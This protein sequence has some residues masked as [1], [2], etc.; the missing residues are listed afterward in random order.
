MSFL[1]VSR[2]VI[3]LLE[4][5]DNVGIATL[6]D[7]DSLDDCKHPK[8]LM[9]DVQSVIVFVSS[10]NTGKMGV[11]SNYFEVIA[12]QNDVI[13]YLIKLGYKA[14][15][16]DSSTKDISF[17]TMGIKASV[18]DISPVNSLV[19]KGIGLAGSIGVILTNAPLEKTEVVDKACINC[20]KCLKVCPI[21]DEPNEKGDLENCACGK[22]VNI[23]PV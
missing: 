4:L 14:K 22:C 11:F 15:V 7:F 12:A 10:N 2:K 5:F 6:N 9:N 16:I 21:R 19:V 13:D 20:M 17:V 8:K 18:G 3:S 23:C 1:S